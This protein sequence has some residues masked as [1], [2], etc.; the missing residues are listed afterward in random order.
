MG[1]HRRFARRVAAAWG[2]VVAA[3]LLPAC[4]GGGAG[5][6]LPPVPART[7]STDPFDPA[8]LHY[9]DLT[10]AE[11]DLPALVPFSDDYVPCDVRYDETDVARVGLR[12]KGEATARPMGDKPSWTLKT[13]EFVSG[14]KLHGKKKVHLHNCVFDASFLHE[15]VAYGLW[16][17]AGVPARRTAHARVTLNGRYLG[18]YVV[19]EPYDD[20]FLDRTFADGDGNLYEGVLGVDVTEPADLELDTN[21]DENDRADLE[22]LAHALLVEP[23]GALEA[24]LERTLVVES[25][26]GYLAVEALLHHWDGYAGQ[27]VPA[28]VVGPNPPHNWYAYGDPSDGGRV[29]FL[30]HSADTTFFDLYAPVLAPPAPAAVLATR[31][32]AHPSLRARFIDRLREILDTAWDVPALLAEIDAAEA[33]FLASVH[34]GD[35]NADFV[36]AKVADE[37]GNLRRFIRLRPEIVRPTLR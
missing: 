23:D 19:V 36:L 30:P 21:E 15:P 9:V 7:A 28:W 29:T 8:V 16:R 13:N 24:A 14:Q 35:A 18:V 10:V 25:F 34:E 33:R 3:V 20:G 1:V 5:A 6:P 27:N 32:L 2:L 37:L 26:L 31:V 4:G 12:I 11:A 22:A 17:R